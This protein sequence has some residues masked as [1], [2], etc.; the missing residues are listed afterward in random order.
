MHDLG[1]RLAKVVALHPAIAHGVRRAKAIRSEELLAIL[2]D[3]ASSK[4]RVEL[5]GELKQ[6]VQNLMLGRVP[7]TKGDLPKAQEVA[8]QLTMQF[9]ELNQAIQEAV[10]KM[11]GTDSK[12]ESEVDAWFCTVM[13][14]ASEI[15]AAQ[16]R[17][18]TFVFAAIVA[19][20]LQIDS[21]AIL[22]Q[23]WNSADVRANLVRIADS[24]VAEADHVLD[25]DKR[26]SKTL[27][28]M[29]DIHRADPAGV[30]LSKAPDN[31]TRCAEG[32]SWLTDDRSVKN[33][34]IA[35]LQ[36]EFDNAC[37]KQTQML[38]AD[39]GKKVQA[40]RSR[41]DETELRF[42]PKRAVFG[43]FRAWF[44]AYGEDGHLLGNLGYCAISE[45]GWAFLVQHIDATGESETRNC[46][47]NR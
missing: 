38:L 12:L 43:S 21:V 11:A 39:T 4:P 42:L 16:S 36:D 26:A 31:L 23:V 41:L 3:L 22:K 33:L 1:R 37:E 47:P 28:A 8:A 34:N 45:F 15:F 7:S 14:R 2:K 18:I 25:R 40:I 5:D 9:P 17:V 13:D 6:A 20:T 44:D 46:T 29:A 27:K 24:T 35:A 32:R 19:I 10:S 30:A